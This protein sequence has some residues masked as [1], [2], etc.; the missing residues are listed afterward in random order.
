MPIGVQLVEDVTA[1]RRLAI[2]QVRA[3]VV[4]ILR[5]GGSGTAAAI[6]E[7]CG[8]P[9]GVVQRRLLRN[10]PAMIRT[11]SRYFTRNGTLWGLT[12]AG[13]ASGS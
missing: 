9:A 13:R 3:I 12:D 11:E 4:A 8:L 1:I 6:A 2:E 7:A 5:L 10:G